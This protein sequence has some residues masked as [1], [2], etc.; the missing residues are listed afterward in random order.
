MT[1]FESHTKKPAHN[2]TFPKVAVQCLADKFVVDQNLYLRI[3]ICA[4]KSASSSSQKTLC[5]TLKPKRTTK[6]RKTNVN[7]SQN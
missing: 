4:K 6:Q 1:V 7:A 3:N 5:I 2:S